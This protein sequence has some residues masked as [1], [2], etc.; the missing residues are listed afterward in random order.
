MAVEKKG[1]VSQDEINRVAELRSKG[2]TRMQIAKA[3][4]ISFVRV[5]YII[6][7]LPKETK[8]ISK[9]VWYRKERTTCTD[10]MPNPFPKWWCDLHNLD[11]NFYRP[12]WKDK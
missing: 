10:T 7:F 12:N 4:C 9:V 3:M 8:E 1:V 6:T 5:K 11:H 2:L